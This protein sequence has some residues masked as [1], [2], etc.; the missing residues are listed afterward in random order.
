MTPPPSPLVK[1][2]VFVP[3]QLVN[4]LNG[5]HGHWRVRY[6]VAQRWKVRTRLAWLEAGQPE[7]P[8]SAHFTFTAYT[9]RLWD[10]EEGVM[11]ACKHVRDVAVRSICSSDDSPTSGHAFSYRQEVRPPG[12]RGVL[13]EVSPR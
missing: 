5:S 6:A 9:A 12:E 1:I 3:G 8:R 10:E 4:P 2:Q 11:A 7:W 13:I